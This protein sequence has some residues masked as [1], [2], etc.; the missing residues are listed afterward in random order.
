ML[1]LDAALKTFLKEFGFVE[2]ERKYPRARAEVIVFVQPDDG[3]K[4]ELKASE[5]NNREIGA[6]LRIRRPQL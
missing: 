6:A 2:I 5:A 1:S 3:T 4:I